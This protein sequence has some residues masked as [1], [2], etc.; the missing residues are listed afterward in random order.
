MTQEQFT[1]FWEQLKA[2]LRAQWDQLTDEDLIQIDG[3]IVRFKR[4]IDLRYG[5]QQGAVSTW[6]NLRYSHWCGNYEGSE[7]VA[8]SPGPDSPVKNWL[9]GS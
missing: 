2:P 4:V 6:A 7:Y 5:E 8:K 9:R 1:A 3:N